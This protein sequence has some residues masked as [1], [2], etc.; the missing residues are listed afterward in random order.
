[1]NLHPTLGVPVARLSALRAW[2]ALS[3]ALRW[4]LA[5]AALLHATAGHAEEWA[6]DG[7]PTITLNAFAKYETQ[8]NSN[9][10]ED[11]QRIP[12][13]S[14][15]EIWGD[16]LIPGQPYK[17][18]QIDTL[19]FEPWLGVKA[20]IG[21]G[22]TLSALLSQRW[23]NGEEDVPGFAF[24][25]NVALSHE[26]YGSLRIGA[27]TTRAWSISD[28]PY[29][30]NLGLSFVWAG[31]GAGYGMLTGAVRYTSRILEVFNGDLVLEGTYDGGNTGFKINRPRFYELYAQYHR[32]P[33]VVDAV[34]QVTRNGTPGAW[35]Q[36]PFTGLTPNA[37]DDSKLGSSGQAM[38]VVMARYD[39]NSRLQLS[40]GLRFNRWSGAYAVETVP[41]ALAQWNNMFNVCW[42]SEVPNNCPS[43]NNLTP[44]Y[45]ARTTDMMAGAR[46]TVGKWTTYGGVAY[47]GKGHTANPSDRAHSEASNWLLDGTLGESYEV[48][49]G[50]KVYVAGGLYHYGHIGLAPFSMPSNSSYTNVD[51]RVAQNGNSV[52]LGVVYAF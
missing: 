41:G 13:A 5:G 28:Y 31:S 9:V 51:S 46:Y 14:K 7:G 23:R 16:Q 39:L 37:A 32:G 20:D 6:L 29:G 42:S 47:L 22:F 11:C 33:L 15:D 17:T 18:T 4:G 30:T 45:S 35:G 50:L 52:L 44:G 2:R 49:R 3:P 38:D 43:S 8:R 27:M 12:S 34:A 26:D 48:V 24:E 40:G 25:R 19:L 1:M 10:C 36:A 21:R